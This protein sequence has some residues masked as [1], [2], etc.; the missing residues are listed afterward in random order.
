MPYRNQQRCFLS[1]QLTQAEQQRVHE[2]IEL[3]QATCTEKAWRWHSPAQLHLTLVYIGTLT[4]EQQQS[5]NKHMTATLA[6]TKSFDYT[7]KGMRCWRQQ[8]QT[9]LIADIVHGKQL[10]QL[11]QTL[12][13]ACQHSH[14]P[15][16]QEHDFIPHITLAKKPYSKQ[17][18][19]Y[20]KA[21]QRTLHAKAVHLM[22]SHF[23]Q[24]HPIDHWPLA[25]C[26]AKANNPP[27]Q[28]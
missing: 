1:L 3:A 10:M 28:S 17:V 13:L 27:K 18:L 21:I 19:N 5:L 2:L 22:H 20:Q 9:L 6:D 25:R 8:Q 26:D 7:I 24:Y 12:R 23:H 11:Q 15:C 4:A 14:M 16:R